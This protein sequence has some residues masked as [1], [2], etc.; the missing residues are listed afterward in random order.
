MR[1]ANDEILIRDFADSDLPLMLKWLM[2]ERVLEYYEGRDVR[3]TMEALAEQYHEPLPGGF[4]VIFEYRNKPVGYGQAYRLSGEMFEE[5]DYPDHGKVVF[6]MDQF[7]GDPEYWNRGIG[8]SFLKLM[9][10]YLKE[11]EGA[12]RILLDPHQ[13]NHRA[14]RAYEKAGFRIVKALPAHELFEGKKED[15]WL[16]ELTLSVDDEI[17]R[18]STLFFDDA[19][20]DVQTIDTS[21]G[22]A[23]Y[24][25]TF[26]LKTDRGGRYVLKL[27]ENDFTFPEKIA[28]WQRTVDEYRK[29][30]Y[31]CPRILRDKSGS[32]PIVDYRGHRCAA[33]AEEYSAYRPA[34]DRFSDDFGQNTALYNSYK[35]DI[36]RM[37]AR[38]AAQYFDYTEYPSAYCLFETF[39]P[40]DK[41]D[42][43]LENALAWKA[44]ADTLP[45]EFAEQVGR[46]WH[47]WTENR[48]ALKKVYP[49]LPTSVFQ[50]DL[51]ASN[52]LL[53]EEGRF[54]GVYDFNLCG[55]D[56]FLNY[57]MRENNGVSGICEALQA[58]AECYRFSDLEK[59]TALMMYRCVKPLWYTRVRELKEAGTDPEAIRASL[60]EAEHELTDEIAFGPSMG[61]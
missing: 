31:Y 17:K 38:I 6:A 60:N 24:R 22:D 12:E 2:D 27:A 34:E 29:L 30:G 26:L 59:D 45:G 47:L 23:D 48:A 52:V 9:A 15:C 18:I 33:Y 28:V 46:I 41:T 25:A 44:Y 56:V 58:A 16:M 54:V 35:R 53:D 7:I 61:Q 37:T 13:K 8:T 49:R 32:F 40:S 57:L 50:A 51:N 14:I 42:E 4:R 3:Y 55:R 43:V 19:P 11:Q 5:Y 1:T 10:R 21:R 39:C 36:W 20:I